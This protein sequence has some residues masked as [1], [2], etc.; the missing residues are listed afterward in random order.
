MSNASGWEIWRSKMVKNFQ[1]C[2]IPIIIVWLI[3][4]L[5]FFINQLATSA[6]TSAQAGSTKLSASNQIKEIEGYKDWA[7]VNAM[8]QLMPKRVAAACAA[9]LMGSIDVNSASNPHLDKYFTVYVNDIGRPAMFSQK[10]PRF[11]EGSV[12]VKEKLSAKD[13]QTPELLT[14]MIKREQG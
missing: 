2:K 6:I 9:A 13:S 1:N 5:V 7:K 8:P 14:V 11:P 12:I 4:A 3:C 10:N